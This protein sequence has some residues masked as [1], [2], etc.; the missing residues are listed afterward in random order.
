MRN[1]L[2]VGTM[3]ALAA[4]GGVNRFDD[5]GRNSRAPAPIYAP[6]ATGPINSACLASDRKARS[7]QL[8][9][10]IQAVADQ[11]LS[12]GDQI[13]AVRFY[14]DPQA[15]QDTRQSDNASDERFWD[16]YSNY[17]KRAAQVC[18]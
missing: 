12:R 16:A 11:T 14:D 9:G 4:C 8:C 7:S 10:C 6:T 1:V 5:R 13:R 17:G 3:L 2:I 18:S 15:A